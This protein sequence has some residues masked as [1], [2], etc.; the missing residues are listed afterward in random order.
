MLKIK[1]YENNAW[2]WKDLPAPKSVTYSEN[3]L[4]SKNAGRL[5]NGYFAGDLVA[6]KKKYEVTFPPLNTTDYGKV[7]QA[8]NQGFTD[9]QITNPS[10]GTDTVSAY[11][12]DLNVEAY[13]WHNKIQYA[14]NTSIS[15]IE[16]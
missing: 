9:V 6:I 14:M 8:V 15:I 7:L 10:G 5:D 2:T 16:R 12:G 3:K 1:V 13:S 4:W 11:F